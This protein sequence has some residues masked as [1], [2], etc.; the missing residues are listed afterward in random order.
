[1]NRLVVLALSLLVGAAAAAN[2][3]ATPPG[4]EPMLDATV[5]AAIEREHPLA[6][7]AEYVDHIVHMVEVAGIDHVGIAADFDGGGGV[8]GWMD[9]TETGNVTAELRKRGYSDADIARIWG[10]NLLRVWQAVIDEAA[11]EGEGSAP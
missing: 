4:A 8:T 2:P 1:M 10:G 11:A 6:T 7:V 5:E 3:A 9:A